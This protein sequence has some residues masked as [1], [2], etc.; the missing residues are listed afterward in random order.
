MVFLPRKRVEYDNMNK[1]YR[2]K[3][4]P[5]SWGKVADWYNDF[6]EKE[7]GSYQKTL[8]L[9][10]LIRLLA[11]KKNEAILDLGCGQ[12]FFSREFAKA[13][14]KVIGVDI[15]PELIAIA[16]KNPLKNITYYVS[17][18]ENL[19]FI[20]NNTIDKIVMIFSIQNVDNVHKVFREC[21]RALKP[22]GKLLIV[23]NHPAFRIPKNSSWGWDPAPESAP[24]SQYG[25]SSEKMY[26][27]ID[28]Y[29]S[30]SKEKIQMR[31][32]DKPDEYTISFHR[33]LQFYFK[34]LS[35]NG[36]GVTRLEEWTSNK[37]SQP[38][39]K[40]AAE[41]KTRKEIPLF[42]FLEAKNNRKH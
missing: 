13:D 27:R 21:N 6:L 38:G 5:T 41:N 23:M 2:S 25:A 28:Q 12:G 40:A 36:F 34:L 42:L 29:M 16:K 10:N 17:S 33:P 37:T 32:G 19:N 1:N 8:I 39:P 26:R 4:D 30:E 14:A 24:R 11:I 7:A 18:A 15:A 22:N 3:N 35:N 31:P 9:P 20:K